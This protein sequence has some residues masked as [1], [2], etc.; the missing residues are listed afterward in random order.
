MLVPWGIDAKK[1]PNTAELLKQTLIT[2]V[3][4]RAFK[5]RGPN[6]SLLAGQLGPK[7]IKSHWRC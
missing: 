1:R 6:S 5:F 2:L 3:R 4:L 7:G